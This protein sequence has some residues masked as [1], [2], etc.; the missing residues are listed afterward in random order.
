M[1]KAI[2]IISATDSV[3][4]SKTSCCFH[5][6]KVILTLDHSDTVIV[7]LQNKFYG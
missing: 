5:L 3:L 7:L 2:I 4:S 1:G 6:C